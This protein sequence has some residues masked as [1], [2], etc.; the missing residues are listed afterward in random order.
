[1]K[2]KRLVV[3]GVS[4][5]S[6]PPDIGERVFSMA[7][8]RAIFDPNMIPLFE[9]FYSG[10]AGEKR[11]AYTI[12]AQ[13][14]SSG[15]PIVNKRGE[16]VGIIVAKIGGLENFCVSPP[17]LSVRDAIKGVKNDISKGKL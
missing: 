14:G 17:Y 15:A 11:D 12:P 8:P 3:D 16:V 5:S 9:G 1:M 2:I 13:G 10:K 4:V 6:S 7:S